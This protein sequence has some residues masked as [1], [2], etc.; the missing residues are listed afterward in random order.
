M[1]LERFCKKSVVTVP[2]HQTVQDAA[3]KMRDHHVGAIVVVEKDRAVG[4]LTD[5]D[6]TLRAI[7]EGRD[8]RTTPIGEVMSRDLKV[9]RS[10]DKID[11]ALSSIRAAGVRRLPIVD[12]AGKPIGMVTLDDLIVLFAGELG[13]AAG[14]VKENRGP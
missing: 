6:I 14:A 11:D 12:A 5:R 3:R 9:L 13:A 7:A 2:P 10:E 1:S 8:P 4:I